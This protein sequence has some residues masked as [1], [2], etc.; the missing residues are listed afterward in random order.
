MRKLTQYALAMALSLGIAVPALAHGPSS[1]RVEPTYQHSDRYDRKYR[2]DHRGRY[3]RHERNKHHKHHDYHPG[4][5]GYHR[6]HDKSWKYKAKH[7]D[8]HYRQDHRYTGNWVRVLPRNSYAVVIGG[9]L[10]HRYRDS[11]YLSGYHNGEKVFFSVDLR[12]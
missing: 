4:N 9:D 8:R 2:D 5:N 7:Y 12:L 3:E 6:G 10:Y 1:I 11:Y